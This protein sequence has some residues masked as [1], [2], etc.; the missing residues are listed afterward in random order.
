MLFTC[1]L[2]NSM[3]APSGGVRRRVRKDELVCHF[4]Q[5]RVIS[6]GEPAQNAQPEALHSAGV[7]YCHHLDEGILGDSARTDRPC[8]QVADAD[9]CGIFMMLHKPRC[10]AEGDEAGVARA[11]HAD[12]TS[13]EQVDPVTASGQLACMACFLLSAFA[14]M[15]AVS[16]FCA[17]P[18]PTLV[19]AAL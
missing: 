11:G 12:T 1:L 4:G 3:S 17:Y 9:A 5:V 7:G 16:K 10:G 2:L 13:V 8:E 18:R 14:S 15:S 6:V 19:S